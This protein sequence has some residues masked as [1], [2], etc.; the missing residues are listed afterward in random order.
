[1]T[2]SLEAYLDR[3]EHR[4]PL[5]PDLDTLTALHRAHLIHIPYE[6]LD[7]HRG[8]RL[9]LDMPTIY[10]KI[11][12]DR[13]GGWC[14]E[15]NGLFAWALGEIGFDVTLLAS[16]VG[17]ESVEEPF[18]GDHLILLVHLD[19]PYLADVGFG[20]GLFEPI[21]LAE[22]RYR[23]GRFEYGLRLDGDRWWFENQSD[24]G[25]GY[26]FTLEPCA[27]ADFAAES[28]RLQTS[29]ASGFVRSTVCFRFTPE[30]VFTLRGAVLHRLTAAGEQEQIIEDAL[31]YGRTLAEVFGLHFD[32]E[33]SAALWEKVWA[34]HQ[35]WKRSQGA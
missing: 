5:R 30:G 17:R 10:R 25:V 8:C 28:Y 20:N 12:E 33:E 19:R 16:C 6:N 15:M 31:S 2:L 4:A 11:V 24:G 7:I 35:V 3:I 27:F 22:G 34:R 9:T 14:F 29:P 18:V 23:Q 26:D 21:P 13:R 1:M 32:G